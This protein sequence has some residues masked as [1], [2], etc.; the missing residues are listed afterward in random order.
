M[1][2]VNGRIFGPANL[3]VFLAFHPKICRGKTSELL[4]LQLNEVDMV[5]DEAE[6]HV[7]SG[8]ETISLSSFTNLLHSPLLKTSPL[9]FSQTDRQFLQMLNVVIN[10]TFEFKS[11]STQQPQLT[12]LAL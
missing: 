5:I 2:C 6:F 9:S 10:Y 11:N 1:M 12:T 8:P 4:L 7:E 3:F